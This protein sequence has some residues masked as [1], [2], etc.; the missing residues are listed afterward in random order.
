MIFLRNKTKFPPK[1]TSPNFSA[2]I[3]GHCK[4]LNLP[5]D[6][7]NLIM[8]VMFDVTM[9]D[10]PVNA[11]RPNVLIE[12]IQCIPAVVNDNC[13]TPQRGIFFRVS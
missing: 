6:I 4:P 1:E 9:Y 7:C 12:S 2:D 8:T 3:V 11:Y 13:G 5:S 10:V